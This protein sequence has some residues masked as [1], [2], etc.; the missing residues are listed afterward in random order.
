M[1]FNDI[2][3]SIIEIQKL[4]CKID[5]LINSAGYMDSGRTS[6]GS[7]TLDNKVERFFVKVRCIYEEFLFSEMQIVT[8]LKLMTLV[9]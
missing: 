1:N 9:F 3:S 6:L 4:H 2:K 7:I 5:I 8:I